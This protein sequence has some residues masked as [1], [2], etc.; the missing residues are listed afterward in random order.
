MLFV[1]KREDYKNLNKKLTNGYISIY[2]KIFIMKAVLP[3]CEGV[4]PEWM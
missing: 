3:F 1:Y 4:G 2:S